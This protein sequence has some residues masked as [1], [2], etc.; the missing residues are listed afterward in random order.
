MVVTIYSSSYVVFSTSADCLFIKTGKRLALD[1]RF[2]DNRAYTPF[3]RFLWTVCHCILDNLLYRYP[4]RY[5]LR[6]FDYTQW[7]FTIKIAPSS[8]HMLLFVHSDDKSY[9]VTHWQLYNG[10]RWLRIRN[11][12][13][14][15]ITPPCTRYISD[16]WSVDYRVTGLLL[17]LVISRQESMY[18]GALPTNGD[19]GE[20][21]KSTAAVYTFVWT[22]L[23]VTTTL[24]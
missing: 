21:I 5:L 23:F 17:Q 13:F 19:K 2:V 3:L 9:A 6:E 16:K 11:I 12:F 7:W 15:N 20:T 8:G 4:S 14:Q 18:I 24:T 22:K 1:V 10:M